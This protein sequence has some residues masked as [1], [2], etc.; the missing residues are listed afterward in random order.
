M[1]LKQEGDRGMFFEA[2]GLGLLIGYIRGGRML[3]IGNIHIRGWLMII[4]AFLL[5]TLPIILG[6]IPWMSKKGPVFSFTAMV[7]MLMVVVLNLDK[8]GF[9]V[10]GFGALL[11]MIAMAYNGLLMPID[12][13]GLFAVG[14]QDI[15]ESVGNGTVVN[16]ISLDNVSHWSKFLGKTIVLPPIYPLA[17][18]ISFGD[19]AISIGVF[20]FVQSEMIQPYH[21][22]SKSKMVHYS[23]NSK[24]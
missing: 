5:Q 2:I 12:L 19:I 3:N 21:F 17:K 6:V 22:K 7:I 11:N 24:W 9:W 16:Y 18:V 20:W 13:N 10:I 23:V 14:F 4:I 1:A 15:V 8:K